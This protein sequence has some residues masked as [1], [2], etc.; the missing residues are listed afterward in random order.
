MQA[1][2]KVTAAA[3]YLAATLTD[4][5]ADDTETVLQLVVSWYFSLTLGAP[6][7]QR[8][9]FDAWCKDAGLSLDRSLADPVLAAM[10]PA[11]IAEIVDMRSH[12]ADA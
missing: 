12:L 5:P 7:E 10:R 6:E 2:P 3:L 8:A 11:V 1:N 9:R 4:L